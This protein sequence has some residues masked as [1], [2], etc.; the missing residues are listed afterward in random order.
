MEN[1]KFYESPEVLFLDAQSEGVL[2]QSGVSGS[3]SFGDYG[4]GGDL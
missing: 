3:G 4:N 1:V 2:C